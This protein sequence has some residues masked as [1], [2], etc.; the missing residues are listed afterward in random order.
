MK[1]NKLFSLCLLS[2]L[3]L[4]A[5]SV[6]PTEQQSVAPESFLGRW[7][8]YLP[9][10]AGWLEVINNAGYFD[11]DLLWYGGSVVPVEDIYFKDNC[12]IVTRISGV[13]RESDAN[14]APVRVHRHTEEYHFMLNGKD[15]LKGTAV[16]IKPDGMGVTT[17]EFIGKRIPDLPAAPD[18]SSIKYGEPIVLF[19]G[20][21]LTGWTLME[22]DRKNGFSVVEGAMVNKPVHVAGEPGFGNLR[23][24]GEYEDF[25]LALQVSIPAGSNSGI[26]LRGIYEVQVLDSYQKPLDSHNMGGIYSRIAPT[27]AAEKPAGEWQDFEII[28]CKRHVTVTLNGQKIIDNQP[29]YGV[30]GGAMT[31]DEFVPGPIYLQGDHGEVSYRNIVLTPIID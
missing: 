21:D 24:S 8:L 18:L 27:V 22:S 10:G 14:G 12:L 13:V 3:F 5:C 30:T 4:G 2:T 28:L 11:A 17:T 25:K 23:T 20:K 16:N 7:S 19:N 1:K 6:T 9:G 31:A 29:L 15:E 26:Y